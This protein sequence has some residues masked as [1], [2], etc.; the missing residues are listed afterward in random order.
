MQLYIPEFRFNLSYDVA[1]QFEFPRQQYNLDLTRFF[2]QRLVGSGLARLALQG[3]QL[4][5]N[6]RDDVANPQEVLLCG[7]ELSERFSFLFL[8]ANDTCCFFDK[9][10][11][12]LW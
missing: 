10:T 3:I 5:L 1:K 4:F 6:F 2:F 9:L 12:I 8:V 11:P 7:I